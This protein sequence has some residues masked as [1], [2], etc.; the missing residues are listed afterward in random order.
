MQGKNGSKL[1]R[2][3]ERKKNLPLLPHPWVGPD[4]LNEFPPLL[5][6][7]C[8]YSPISAPNTRSTSALVCL[9]F[10]LHFLLIYYKE[11]SLQGHFILSSYVQPTQVYQTEYVSHH[12]IHHIDY[13]SQTFCASSNI[14]KE[15]KR[16]RKNTLIIFT[17]ATRFRRFYRPS[18]E[19]YIT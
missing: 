11:L 13:I 6:W 2:S 8:I 7:L 10:Y 16:K 4:I 19:V 3:K 14:T 18:S 5:S 17:I 12:H 9:F 15:E 1:L